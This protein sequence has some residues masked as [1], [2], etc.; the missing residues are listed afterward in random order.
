MRLE[1][2]PLT[3]DWHHVAICGPVSNFAAARAGGAGAAGG[4]LQ[5]ILK[6][7]APR[8][9]GIGALVQV[10]VVVVA[11]AEGSLLST[12]EGGAIFLV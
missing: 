3:H 9:D 10:Q 12:V 2:I 8:R 4:H 1:S 11:T 5:T 6:D 7:D